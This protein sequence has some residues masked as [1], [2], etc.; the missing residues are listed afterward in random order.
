MA[1]C[2][3]DVHARDVNSCREFWLDILFSCYSAMRLVVAT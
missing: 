3:R 2:D 1:L